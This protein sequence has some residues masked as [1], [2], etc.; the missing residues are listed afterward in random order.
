MVGDF[1]MKE[2]KN[3]GAVKAVGVFVN[4]VDSLGI[5]QCG[6]EYLGALI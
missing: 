4:F 5:W 1:T 3:P 6:V 2:K